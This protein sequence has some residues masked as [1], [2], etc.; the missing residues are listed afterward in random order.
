MPEG[1]ETDV[2]LDRLI[3]IAVVDRFSSVVLAYTIVYRPE[4]N[5]DDILK[6]NRDAARG[7][8][9]PMELTIPNLR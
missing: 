8:W 1:L 7:T 3:L 9:A 5:A 6:V 4:V 2:R